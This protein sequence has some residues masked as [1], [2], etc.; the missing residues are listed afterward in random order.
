MVVVMPNPEGSGFSCEVFD[1]ANDY[2]G[3]R[4]THA[5]GNQ[6]GQNGL[7]ECLCRIDTAY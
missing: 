2:R 1:H 4:T 7:S 6:L 3:D 5:S